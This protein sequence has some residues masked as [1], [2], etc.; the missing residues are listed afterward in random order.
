MKKLTILVI[1]ILVSKSLFAQVGIGTNSPQA[2]LHVNQGNVLFQGPT[3]IPASPASPIPNV[4]GVSL[5]FNSQKGAFRA[6]V[7]DFAW[8]DGNIGKASVAMGFYTRAKGNNST[9]FGNQTTADGESSFAMGFASLASSPYSNAMGNNVQATGERSTAMGNYV[10]TNE[11]TGSFIIG[12][13]SPD[14][15]INSNE[16]NQMLM[17]FTGGYVLVSGNSYSGVALNSGA[18]AWSVY[19]DVTK[20]EKFLPVNGEETLNKISALSLTTWNYKGQDSKKFRHHG[21]MA[22][23]FYAAFGKDDLGT[24]GNDTTINQAD[25]DG[26]NFEA[27]HALI[28]RTEVL[29]KRVDELEKQ[30]LTSGKKRL[31]NP[32]Y[33]SEKKKRLVAGK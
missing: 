17:R 19:S 27:I 7:A 28:K 8:N 9:A 30:V 31:L 32:V 23:D 6:G 14:F 22:Q 2:L 12:D 26:V 21:P 15:L 25:F 11:K 18:N 29:Q 3:S 13:N 16:N 24:M 4:T 1:S 10:S 5:M 20:K 33:T